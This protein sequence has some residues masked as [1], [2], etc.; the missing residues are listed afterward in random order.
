MERIEEVLGQAKSVAIAGHIRADGDCIGSCMGMYNYMKDNYPDV[1]TDVY[2]EQPGQVFSYIPGIS[3]VRTSCDPLAVYDLMLVLDT[4]TRERLGVAAELFGQAKM[5]VCIDHHVSNDGFAQINHIQGG[6]SSAAEVLYRLLDPEKISARTAACLYTGIIHDT[7]VFQYKA[8]TPETMRA[9]ARLMETGIDFHKIID[10]SFCQKTYIQ[11][12][13]MG[14]VLTE[15]ILL[16]G[17]ACIAGILKKKEMVFY[18]VEGKDLDGV[19]AQLR[20]TK[21]VEVAIFLYELKD[22]EYKVSLRSN[23]KVD[24]N[25]VAS[26]F[27]GG[28]HALAAGCQIKGTSYDVLNNLLP[29]IEEQL[30]E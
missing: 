18:G 25:R 3:Q 21:G 24:V 29:H 27:G 20:L 12:Q 1:T 8:T 15:S 22:M 4:S 26:Y 9:A 16:L 28:G 23:G 5:T 13:V 2:L 6:V 19:V 10:E 7:G 14:R 17:G 11:N 30:Q